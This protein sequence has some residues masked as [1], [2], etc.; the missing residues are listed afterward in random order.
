MA[1]RY[2]QPGWIFAW[3][4][5]IKSESTAFDIHWSPRTTLPARSASIEI[6]PMAGGSVKWKAFS[7]DLPEPVG[8]GSPG[9]LIWTVSDLPGYEA[10][11][12]DDFEP[13]SMELRAYLAGPA[14]R[15]AS[16]KTWGDVV[17]LAR[18]EMDPKAVA[19][20]ALNAEAHRLAGT[21][22][23][24]TRIAPVCRFV[25]KQV[26]YLLVAIDSDSMAGY[27]PHPAGDVFDN[28][29]GDCKDKAVLLCTMLRVIGV[30][31]RVILVNSGEPMLNLSDWPSAHF[32]H[33]IVAIL[34]REPA[35]EGGTTVRAGNED[36][37]LFDPTNE[38]VPF[39]LLPH[40]D[41][42]GLGLILAPGVASPVLIPANTEASETV[43]IK[44]NMTLTADGSAKFD[45][46]EEKAGLA[47]AAAI[48]A[49]E[50]VAR[51]E[52]T[53]A[54]ERRIQRRVPLISDLTW[55]SSG[56]EQTRHWTRTAAFSAQYVGKRIPGGMYVATDLM[57]LVPD[58]QP[59][60]GA[61]EG[62]VSF[63]PTLTRR[64]IR[65]HA[66]AGWEFAEIP[67]DWS[68]KT[69]AGEGSMHYS[70]T[71]GVLKGEISVRIPGG[72]LDQGKY[73]ELRSLVRSA[74]AAERRP[75]VLRRLAPAAH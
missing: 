24:W 33:A 55:E 9:S 22:G 72:V 11:V 4:I 21:G 69:E 15:S 18:A 58:S 13:N 27:R 34:C 28:R 42:G 57:S 50:T 75:V 68:V 31:A 74:N 17:R 71:D 53:G 37:M 44:L 20:P 25:Q 62:W 64:E 63:A 60:A 6:I 39:G 23:L 61:A 1:S 45:L 10:N 49:D 73:L 66:P 47:A 2:L 70:L 59:W 7:K 54:L 40:E 14:T 5:E 65:L 41:V 48:T 35:P 19:T 32:N 43:S 67:A 8:G 38:E 3:E 36:Y 52:R 29:Y 16:S 46:S 26:S 12:P 56:D 30:E 51:S